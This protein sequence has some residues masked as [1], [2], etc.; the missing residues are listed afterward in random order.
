MYVPPFW[1]GVLALFFLELA[2]LSIA[3]VVVSARKGGGK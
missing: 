1:C 2:V 3:A